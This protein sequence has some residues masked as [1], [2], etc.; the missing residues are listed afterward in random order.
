MNAHLA[1]GTMRVAILDKD[2]TPIKPFSIDRCA[3][4]T[5]DNVRHH[6]RWKGATNLAPV[7]GKT[8]RLKFEWT[9]GELYA[10]WTGAE[11]KWNTPDTT[12]WSP[13]ASR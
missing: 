12:T 10:F 2:E 7:V 13:P 8:V 11:R 9:R 1:G 6:V 3:P 4:L 5:G